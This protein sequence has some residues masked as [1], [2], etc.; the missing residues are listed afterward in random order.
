MPGGSLLVETDLE[1]FHHTSFV[2]NPSETNP[3][4]AALVFFQH[5][6]LLYPEHG[7]GMLGTSIEEYENLNL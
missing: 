6:R 4:R 2:A 3:G 1:E 5:D 7:T